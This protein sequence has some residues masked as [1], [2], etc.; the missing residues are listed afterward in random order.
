MP[1]GQIALDRLLAPARKAALGPTGQL[2]SSSASAKPSQKILFSRQFDRGLSIWGP[3]IWGPVIRVSGIPA[4]GIRAACSW[5]PASQLIYGQ[6]NGSQLI[7]SQLTWGGLT[8]GS[9]LAGAPAGIGDGRRC[10][11]GCS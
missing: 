10:G 9:A 8:G 11:C 3:A 6:L 1:G 7:L 4:S 2:C 5:A